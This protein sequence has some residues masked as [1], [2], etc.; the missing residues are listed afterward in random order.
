MTSWYQRNKEIILVKMK[1]RKKNKPWYKHWANAWKRCNQ[2][3]HQSYKWYGGRGIEL[4]MGMAEFK[5]LWERDR[6]WEFQRPSIDRIDADGHYEFNNCRF[7][8]SERNTRAGRIGI[9][10]QN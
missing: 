4:K 6:A 1:E 7:I 5:A 10:V 3:Q 8:E 2:E 9:L